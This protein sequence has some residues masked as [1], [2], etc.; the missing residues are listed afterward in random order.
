M[1]ILKR[2][3]NTMVL[4]SPIFHQ[5][6]S[7]QRKSASVVRNLGT[8]RSSCHK[9]LHMIMITSHLA[10]GWVATKKAKTFNPHLQYFLSPLPC[11]FVCCC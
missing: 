4:A 1:C 7:M 2:G 3:G 8:S 6:M 10:T 9:H 11:R 5:S